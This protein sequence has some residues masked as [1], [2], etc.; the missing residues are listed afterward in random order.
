IKVKGSAYAPALH[1]PVSFVEVRF[2]VGAQ[3]LCGRFTAF[4][5]NTDE[6]IDGGGPSAACQ[7][8][9]GDGISEGTEA[10][11]DGD[12]IDGN[13]CD[14]NCTLTACGNGIQTAGEACDDG[15]LVDGDGCDANC[16]VTGCGNG[17]Q[18]GSE[19]CDDG[20]IVNGDGCDN[21]CTPTGCGNGV[22]TVGESCD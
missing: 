7:Q 4:K 13:G 9:C 22:Q 3:S 10:C 21:N 8:E 19:Q 11:D 12:A 16:T 15:N 6:R 2:K 14:T 1:G 17:V 5:Q 18:S 20:N